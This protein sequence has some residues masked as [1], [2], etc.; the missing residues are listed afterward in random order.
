[1][2]NKKLLIGGVII[3]VAVLV[4]GYFGFMSAATYYY[5]V[6]EYNA[7]LTDAGIASQT[8]RV[9]G[10]VAPDFSQNGNMT[11][12]MLQDNGGGDANLKVEYKGNLPE[13]FQAGRQV[14]VEGTYDQARSVFVARNL[15]A[16]CSSKYQPE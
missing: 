7:R 3:L 1:M 5:E 15:I 9:S 2:K 13:T 11:Y 8:S 12:F 14:V 16:K 6:G 10:I 4:L